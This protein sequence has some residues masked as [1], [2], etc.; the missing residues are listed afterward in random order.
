KEEISMA[1]WLDYAAA[2]KRLTYLNLKQALDNADQY[3]RKAE[4]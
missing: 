2:R 1:A 3:I 4:Q